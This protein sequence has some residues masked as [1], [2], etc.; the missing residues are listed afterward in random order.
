MTAIH[1][2]MMKLEGNKNPFFSFNPKPEDRKQK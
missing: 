2:N 1:L